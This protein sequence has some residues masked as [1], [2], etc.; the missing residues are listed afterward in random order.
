MSNT[1]DGRSA[2]GDYEQNEG[3]PDLSTNDLQCIEDTEKCR[4]RL[5]YWCWRGECIIRLAVK[6]RVSDREWITTYIVLINFGCHDTVDSS[7]AKNIVKATPSNE[8]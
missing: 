5:D 8:V 7:P 1:W 4:R 6:D 2:D 3:K